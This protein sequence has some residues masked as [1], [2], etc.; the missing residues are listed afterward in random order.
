MKVG[1]DH[2]PV[3]QVFNWEPL[4]FMDKAAEYGYEGVALPG[5]GLLKDTA[6]RQQVIEKKE[7]LGLYIDLGGAGIDSALSGKPTQELVKSWEPAFELALELGA[8]TLVAGL[9][10]WP[11]QGRVIR[12]EGKS[13]KDQIKGGIATL[14]EVSKM[15][16][17]HNTPV[18][19]HTSFF[20]ADEYVQIMEAVN[21]P[22]VGICLDTA[23]AFLV[24]Q[25][26]V[27]FA[28]CVAPWVKATHLKDSSIYLQAEGADW[29]GGCPLGRGSVDLPAVV[30]LLY[31][32]NPKT[33]LTIEDHWGRSP[34]P[35]FD[36]EFL[37]SIPGW[38]GAQ[39]AALLKH[40]Q[41]GD[42]SLKAG[43][44]PTSE[45][46][47]HIDWKRV[48]P[49]RARYNAIYAKQLRDEVVSSEQKEKE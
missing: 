47:K 39:V 24:L 23:N 46:S 19:I 15:A 9:G 2:I 34:M 36:A 14:R 8:E 40:L 35:V 13:V 18:T 12:E 26:P 3:A 41:N 20:T 27:E 6:Y 11:W 22:Y 28:L 25:D 37:N 16:Q 48:F 1:L 4:Q 45:E 10:T 29:L 49:E 7:Q 44:H 38:D 31:K 30:E 42:S 32:A 43:L 5:R 21:S 33:N 17:D